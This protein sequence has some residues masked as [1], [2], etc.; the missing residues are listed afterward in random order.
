MSIWFLGVPIKWATH[1]IQ[2]QW[3]LVTASSEHFKAAWAKPAL[4]LIYLESDLQTLTPTKTAP[5]FCRQMFHSDKL[6][7]L[8]IPILVR[9][10]AR[11]RHRARASALQQPD[12]W[13]YESVT[14]NNWEAIEL[15]VRLAFD[16]LCSL[17]V[18][19]IETILCEETR[20]LISFI[21][22]QAF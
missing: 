2:L 18:G 12:V 9:S 1:K 20:Q 21:L 3:L 8:L 4:N 10:E 17:C 15:F 7:I 11:F 14:I 13:D 19:Y 6:T 22:T 16:I 5:T